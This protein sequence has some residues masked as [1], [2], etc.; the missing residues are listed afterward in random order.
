MCLLVHCHSVHAEIRWQFLGVESAFPLWD[1][2]MWKS[3][4]PQSYLSGGLLWFCTCETYCGAETTGG[5]NQVGSAV[6]STSFLLL[7]KLTPHWLCLPFNK[8]FFFVRPCSTSQVTSHRCFSACQLY[9]VGLVLRLA[10]S[11]YPM[12]RFYLSVNGKSWF[13]LTFKLKTI[14]YPNHSRNV[15]ARLLKLSISLYLIQRV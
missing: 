10:A 9:S 1:F 6:Q 5:F 8:G 13:F 3:V 4:Y 11:F 12:R 7:T 14:V 2:C 15:T